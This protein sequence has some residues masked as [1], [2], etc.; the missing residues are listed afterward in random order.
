MPEKQISQGGYLNKFP[1]EVR[2]RAADQTLDIRKFEIDLYWK[3]TTY[4]WTFMAATLAVL[5]AIQTSDADNKQNLSVVLSCLGFVFSFTW[6]CVNRDSKLWQ[7][8]W[9]KHLDIL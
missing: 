3:M 1:E 8:N 5:I 4:F 9:E 6:A 2:E 7:E